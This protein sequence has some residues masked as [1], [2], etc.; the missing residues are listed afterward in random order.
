MQGRR[1][2]FINIQIGKFDRGVRFLNLIGDFSRSRQV[3]CQRFEVV[4]LWLCGY[5]VEAHKK[6]EDYFRPG[7]DIVG[8]HVWFKLGLLMLVEAE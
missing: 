2:D 1:T 8:G 7:V 5:Q 6:V 3:F 4:Y